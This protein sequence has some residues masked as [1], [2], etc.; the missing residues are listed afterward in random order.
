MKA[1]KM[2]KKASARTIE[3]YAVCGC[4][5]ALCSCSTGCTCT[6]N[7]NTTS[8]FAGGSHVTNVGTSKTPSSQLSGDMVSG[9]V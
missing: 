5:Y 9:T 3:T 2:K 6:C 4:V 1:M 7:G 8:G